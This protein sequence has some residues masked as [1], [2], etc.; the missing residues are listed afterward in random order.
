MAVSTS[1]CTSTAR[2]SGKSRPACCHQSSG[3]SGGA[4]AVQGGLVLS[5]ERMTAVEID[6][7]ARCAVVEPGAF[8]AAVKAAAAARHMPIR[9]YVRAALGTVLV[10]CEG[11]DPDEVPFFTQHG[12]IGPR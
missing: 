7:D 11:L 10:A 6:P 5:L 4:S 2:R 1:M 3:L 12:P 8:N 9:A